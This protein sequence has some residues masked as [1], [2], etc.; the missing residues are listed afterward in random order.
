MRTLLIMAGGT[1]GHVY[2]ALSVADEMKRRGVNVVWLGTRGGLEARVVPKAGFDI[3]WITIRGLRGTGLLGTLRAPFLIA[4]AMFQTL[5]VVL[6]RRPAAVLGM[7]GFVSGPGAL[8]AWLL[9]IPVLIHEANAIAGFTNRWLAR[10]ARTAMTGFPIELGPRSIHVG[11]PVRADILAVAD[12]ADRLAGRDG[13][14]RL[15]VVGGSQGARTLNTR[16]PELLPGVAK[17]IEVRHQA[18]RD[19]SGG[20][21]DAY[22]RTGLRAEVTEFID[23]MAEAYDWADLVICR[24][25]AMTVAEVCASGSAAVFVPFPAAVGDHQTCNARLLCDRQAAWMWPESALS[26]ETVNAFFDE[27]SREA[28]LERARRARE[29]AVPDSTRRVGDQ[30]MEVLHA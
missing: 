23:D 15:L 1:G 14:Y 25:G 11:N 30:C 12:P 5:G 22:E 9:R 26:P 18:G 8:T 24:A 13:P 21:R 7:G 28:I 6:R 29:M 10:L 20:V 19:K 27:L 4:V 3:E 2:P 16:L 17:P